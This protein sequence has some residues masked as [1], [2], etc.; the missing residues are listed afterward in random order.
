[1]PAYV[2]LHLASPSLRPCQVWLALLRDDAVDLSDPIAV[3]AA[4]EGTVG[5]KMLH[6]RSASGG[7]GSGGGDYNDEDDDSNDSDDDDADA[8]NDAAAN[9]DN[10]RDGSRGV[11]V[12][13][14]AAAVE[15]LVAGL[16]DEELPEMEE[17]SRVAC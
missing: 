10:T 5:A 6:P 15:A 2:I 8:K 13:G 9:G 4:A 17:V 1:V 12:I 16:E 7:G 11:E 14:S 3:A